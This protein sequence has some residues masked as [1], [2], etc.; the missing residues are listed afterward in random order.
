MD[1]VNF[2]VLLRD[3][4]LDAKFIDLT[5]NERLRGNQTCSIRSTHLVFCNY[6]QVT[7]VSARNKLI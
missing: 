6:V 2:K 4:K 5:L 7:I 3:L 1:R